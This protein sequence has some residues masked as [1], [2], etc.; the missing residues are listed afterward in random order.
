MASFFSRLFRSHF[1]HGESGEVVE[2]VEYR[3]LWILA[4]PERSEGQWRVAG[5]IVK[6]SGEGRLERVFQRA[7]RLPTREQAAEQSIGKGQ[8]IIDERGEQMFA[9]G[10][11][12]GRV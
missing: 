11:P 10:E 5:K 8:R 9:D 12:G 3:G 7:D 4:A 6:G 1:S 2:T